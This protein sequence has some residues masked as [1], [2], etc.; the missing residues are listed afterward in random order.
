MVYVLKFQ[1]FAH[2]GL[3]LYIWVGINE[4]LVGIANSEDPDQT[5]SPESALFV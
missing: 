3:I 4:M 2:F 5:A 1:T